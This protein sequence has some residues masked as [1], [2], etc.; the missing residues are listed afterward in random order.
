LGEEETVTTEVSNDCSNHFIVI[1]Q[2]VR[3]IFEQPIQDYHTSLE[4]SKSGN[5]DSFFQ[6]V[7]SFSKIFKINACQG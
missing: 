3:L 1:L 6:G 5:W 2:A 4:D 7:E